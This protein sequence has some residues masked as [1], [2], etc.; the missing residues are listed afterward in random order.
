MLKNGE[1][2]ICMRITV[3]CR[4]VDISIKRSVAVE[5]WNQT[6]ECCTS[7]GKVGKE[8]NRYIDTMK[9]KVLQI[10]RELEIDGVRITADAIRDKLY[11]RDE[12]Q[13][14][15]IEVYTEHNKRCRALIG[16]DFSAS[17]VEKF[18]TSLNTLKT[19]IKHST[20]KN[21]ILLKEVS[22]V[23]IQDFEFFLKAERNMQHNSALKHLK[24]LK[25]IVRIALANEWVKKDP[26]VGIQFKH[27]KI[28]VDF[29]SQEELDRIKNKEFSIKRLEVVRD[30]F[31]FCTYTGLAFIDVKQLDSS[32]LIADSNGALWIRKP[33]Q[34]T[35]NMC[36][37][38]VIQPAK[39]ILEKYK[40]HPECLKKNV[41]LPVLSNQ[42][43]NAYLKEIAD[44]CGITKKMSSHV[45]RH[46]AATTVF[47]ANNVSIENVAKILGHSSTKMTQHY[48]K[49][50]DSSILRDMQSVEAK[51]G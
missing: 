15:L 30:I 12:S 27:D 38:P 8:L 14:T 35:G 39:T 9:A 4:T 40:E 45:A 29:L 42:K 17:T 28:D 6:R 1:A 5:Y 3:N 7:T 47:L 37:I 25:K 23:F 36:N 32:H 50:L 44:L 18:D 2:P 19:F 11:G 31:L 13:K 49:V 41:L 21:D 34:K 16:K 10:H 46:T 48:A 24:N 43:T 26:F 51:F 20:K 22:R 33:R